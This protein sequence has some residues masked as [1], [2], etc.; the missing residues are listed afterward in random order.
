MNKG[1]KNQGVLN[2]AEREKE[3]IKRQEEEKLERKRAEKEEVERRK[4]E[5]FEKAE[6]GKLHPL[7]NIKFS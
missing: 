5:N 4:K 6:E 7:F 2:L 3:D 1:S